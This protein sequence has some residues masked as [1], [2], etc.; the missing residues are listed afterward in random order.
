MAGLARNQKVAARTGADW[1]A[2]IYK[3]VWHD[4]DERE[5]KV[6]VKFK[7]ARVCNGPADSLADE[8]IPIEEYGGRLPFESAA[9]LQ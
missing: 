4:Y 9:A 7:V 3:G 2:G 1:F 6:V 5:G 8:I